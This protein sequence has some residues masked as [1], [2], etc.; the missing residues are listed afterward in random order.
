M[1]N[2]TKSYKS[3][4][5]TRVA[6]QDVSFSVEEGE[7]YGLFGH[8]GAGKTTLVNQL[9]GLLKPDSGEI[10]IAGED[11]VKNRNRGRYLCSVQPQSK[12]PLGELTPRAAMGIMGKLRGASDAEVTERTDA[13]LDALN[14]REWADVE[15]NKLSGGVLRLTGFCMAAIRPGRAVILDEPTNDVDPVRRRLLWSAIREL[16]D[17]GTAVLLV[18]HS[19]RE[20]EGVVDK[21]AILDEGRVLLQ[22]DA[23]TIKAAEGQGRMKLI[24]PV[25][26]SAFDAP[27]LAWAEEATVREQELAVTFTRERSAEALAWATEES[28]QRRIGDYALTEVTL[29]DIY[30]DVLSSK[31]GAT[32][33][34]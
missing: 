23:S 9:L 1:E 17:D 28:A 32:S 20:A 6:N 22:G 19:I 7:V 34:R 24:A 15:G 3:R 13:L 25:I 16:T 21:I 2:V 8:N 11:I 30:I 10:R 14:I 31:E 18:T 4:G 27:L 26:D 12:T 5:K 33:G 29:E